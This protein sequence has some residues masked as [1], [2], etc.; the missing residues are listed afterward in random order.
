MPTM[1]LL[2]VLTGYLIGSIPVAYLIAKARGVDIFQ[3][4]T[5]NPGAANT[6]RSVGRPAGIL[7]FAADVARGGG[8]VLL[9]RAMG[10]ESLEL[11]A[12]AGAA[13]VVGHWY[14]IFLRFRGGAG[15]APAV[16]I[17]LATVPLAAGI[18]LIPSALV[19][20]RYSSTG[21][22]AGAG[23]TALML[24]SVPLQQIGPALT[25]VGITAL[26]FLHSRY[27]YRTRT[28]KRGQSTHKP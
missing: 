19:L 18:G 10:V 4:G 27:V 14:P 6:F 8:A 25:V 13:A 26:V 5:G 7:V 17:A 12:A 15:L 9:A 24:A 28:T 16:G 2:S 3:V 23:Y 1:L 20:I 11:Q 21:H 22:A